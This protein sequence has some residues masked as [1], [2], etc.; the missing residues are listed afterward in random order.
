MT[1]SGE[2]LCF[3]HVG[4][5]RFGY[6]YTQIVLKYLVKSQL[7]FFFQILIYFTAFIYLGPKKFWIIFLSY[8]ENYLWRSAILDI[9]YI[10]YHSY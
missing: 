7:F 3:V 10:S 5:F 8:W 4:V 1:D 9:I 2:T 6:I